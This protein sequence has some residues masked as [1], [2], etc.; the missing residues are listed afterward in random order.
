MLRMTYSDHFLSV[1]VRPSNRRDECIPV[2]FKITD[3]LVYFNEI[4][5]VG[6][7][8][9]QLIAVSKVTYKVSLFV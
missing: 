9:G 8:T 5:S 3:T 6:T 2:C 4:N 1:V 7:H